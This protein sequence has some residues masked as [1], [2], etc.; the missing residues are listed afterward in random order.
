MAAAINEYFV[1]HISGRVHFDLDSRI[2]R[3]TALFLVF[4]IFIDTRS[5]YCLSRCVID[6]TFAMRRI[7]ID[8]VFHDF[9]SSLLF[10]SVNTGI[11]LRS[12]KL[13]GIQIFIMEYPLFSVIKSSSLS[14]YTE[15]SNYKPLHCF[16]V[17]LW[18]RELYTS[19]EKK[20]SYRLLSQ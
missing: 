10:I 19:I 2:E 15:Y 11:L 16:M 14:I 1:H 7:L 8:D 17:Q 13:F 18:T 20:I 9:L 3:V 6:G 5:S 12:R 4:A